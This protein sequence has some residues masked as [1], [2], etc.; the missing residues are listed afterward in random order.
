MD[1]LKTAQTIDITPTWEETATVLHTLATRGDAQGVAYAHTEMQRMG[2][3]ADIAMIILGG[4]RR[5]DAPAPMDLDE[6]RAKCEL[7]LKPTKDDP[8]T[9]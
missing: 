7:F 9:L 4:H 3:L 6:L 5:D 8:T 2:K 1:T